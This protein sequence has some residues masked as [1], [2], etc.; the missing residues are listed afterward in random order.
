MQPQYM[1]SHRGVIPSIVPDHRPTYAHACVSAFACALALA[2]TLSSVSLVLVQLLC[3][4]SV[5]P[6]RA[7]PAH[8]GTMT[9]HFHS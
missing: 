1:L 6:V 3:I 9:H 4:C 8:S 7:L 2:F 5:Q